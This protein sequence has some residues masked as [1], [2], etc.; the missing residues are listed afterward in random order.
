[1]TAF[2]TLPARLRQWLKSWRSPRYRYHPLAAAFTSSPSKY[3]GS[4]ALPVN[5]CRRRQHYPHRNC[6]VF[7]WAA[8]STH[9]FYNLWWSR[10]CNRVKWIRKQAR[11]QNI[12]PRLGKKKSSLRC[13][14]YIL[15]SYAF[16]SWSCLTE[17]TR[18]LIGL[19]K[20]QR[21]SDKVKDPKE[22]DWADG[23]SGVAETTPASP[24]SSSGARPIACQ[25]TFQFP[26]CV[27]R[28]SNLLSITTRKRW[29]CTARSDSTSHIYQY[30]RLRVTFSVLSTKAQFHKQKCTRM[31]LI[32]Q[33]HQL[34]PIPPASSLTLLSSNCIANIKLLPCYIQCSIAL[35][36]PI[37]SLQI[38]ASSWCNNQYFPGCPKRWNSKMRQYQHPLRASGRKC[39]RLCRGSWRYGGKIRHSWHLLQSRGC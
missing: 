17:L 30:L 26:A 36:S 24:D 3:G 27:E 33:S 7:L 25:S 14:L 34:N 12:T 6:L 37:V 22:G 35:P 4:R 23:V 32:C 8:R 38:C 19:N 9:R 28:Y 31:R 10:I 16:P 15:N 39:R 18:Q 21:V 11:I 29:D 5:I 1:M 2:K 13:M 20:G